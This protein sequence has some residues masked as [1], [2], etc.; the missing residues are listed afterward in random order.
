MDTV[1][2]NGRVFFKGKFFEADVLISNGMIK[3]VGRNLSGDE[4]YNAEGMLVLPGLVD[5][6]VH[7]REP[8]ATQKEDFRTGTMAAVA[9]GFTT[10][11][12]MPNNPIPTITAERL[13]EK[14]ALAKEKAICDVLFHFGAT[15]SNFAEVKK[16][17]AKSLKIYLGKTTGELYLRDPSSLEKHLANFD[18]NFVFH[19]SV[20]EGNES[21]QIERTC[22]NIEMVGLLSKK[23]K[24]KSHIAH[25]SSKEEVVA[26]KGHA[27]TVETAPHY[28]F[29]S[30]KDSERLGNLGTVY[31]NL[32]EESTRKKLW[33]E[34]NDIDCIA[35]DHAPHTIEDKMAGAH[36]FPG[37]ETSLAVMLQ[38]YW[39]R[40][41]ELEWIVEA[42]S[43]N[44][45]RIFG[46]KSVGKIEEG[47][48]A[49]ITILDLKKEWVV[50]GEELYTK[51]KWSPFEG[52]KLKG[53]VKAVFYDGA[54]IFDGE[55]L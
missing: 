40:E 15:D 44:P 43:E 21:T 52:R 55:F 17:G 41:L 14:L 4:R 10:V 45:A 20:S 16:S 11:I 27:L 24:R 6:H 22:D 39:E 30:K 48:R 29:L 19:A 50:K 1:V 36:G 42:M 33:E 23:Y 9:G 47:Y 26:A 35:T 5:P 28:L 38:A 32:R 49:N 37:L 46:L 31:P 2:T 13:L 34:I 8:G 53:K 54:L 12:D 18:G 51:C 3:R 25:A 7:L